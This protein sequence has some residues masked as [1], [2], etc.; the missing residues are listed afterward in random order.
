[1]TVTEHLKANVHKHDTD[2]SLVC[3]VAKATKTKEKIVRGAL[4]KLTITQWW[5]ENVDASV[6]D[7]PAKNKKIFLS[8][9]DIH[10]KHDPYYKIRSAAQSLKKGQYI[11]DSD[12]RDFVAKMS[13]AEYRRPSDNPEF[14]KYKGKSGGVVY[15]GHPESIK[16][17]K[18]EGVLK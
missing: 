12:F 17:K 15:W 9:T 3:A 2:D 11:E 5:K 16:S 4:K 18:V 6:K 14:E 7:R 10:S 1:M 13:T 8:D